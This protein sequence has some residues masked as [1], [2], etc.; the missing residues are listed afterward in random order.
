MNGALIPLDPRLSLGLQA[1]KSAEN[2][3]I[4][5]APFLCSADFAAIQSKSVDVQRQRAAR[6]LGD[7][8]SAVL[9]RPRQCGDPLLSQLLTPPHDAC[10]PG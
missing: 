6:A 7:Y 5:N 10:L 9:W 3:H 1:A 4:G 2:G 8:G